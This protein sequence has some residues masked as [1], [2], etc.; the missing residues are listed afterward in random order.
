MGLI[1]HSLAFSF[2]TLL[3][4]VFGYVRDAVLAYQ[5]G[6]SSVTDAFFIAFRLPNTFRRLLGEGGFNAAFIPLYADNVKKR[7]E[8]D[9]L[10]SV[11]TFYTLTNLIITFL[12]IIFASYII[13]LIAPGIKNKEHF[14]L[15]VFFARWFFIYLF[16]IGISSFFMAVLNVKGKFFVPAFAQGI[17]NIVFSLIVA[18]LGHHYGIYSLL[19]GVLI[20]GILQAFFHIPFL[21]GISLGLSFKWGSDIK[22]LIRRLV[23]S[24]LG[25]GIAQLSFFVDTLLASFLALGAVSYLYYANRVFQLPLGVISAGMANSL[26]SALSIEGNY[27][28]NTTLAVRFVLLLSV[29][30]TAGLIVLSDQIIGLL[31]MRGKF[32]QEDATIASHVLKAYSLGLVFFSLQKLLGATFFAKGDTKTPMIASFLTVASEGLFA[33][34]YAF[35]L[36]M[37]VVGLALGTS[38]SALVGFIYFLYKNSIIKLTSIINLSTKSVL[39]SLV[40]IFAIYALK[41][42]NSSPFTLFYIIPIGMFTYLVCLIVLREELALLALRRLKSFI[43]KFVNS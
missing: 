14:P 41:Q 4:R 20:G 10:S 26:L 16:F 32:T 8:K 35:W 22:L 11:F 23:P 13:L 25:F 39:S 28:S 29:P 31:Y 38:T 36:K 37:G 17:F 1:R 7:K 3:S 40:M 27:K 6:V 33:F 12:G 18:L 2:G 30:A 24:L 19:L 21:K 5:F 9:F 42:L 34:V 43:Y 15:A